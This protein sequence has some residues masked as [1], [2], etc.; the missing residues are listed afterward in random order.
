M[1]RDLKFTDAEI[2]AALRAGGGIFTHAALK[3]ECAPNTIKN[4]V[5]RSEYLQVVL[6]DINEENLDIAESV[7]M[8][9]IR[10]GNM[11]GVIFYLKTKGKKRGFSERFEI[12]GKDGGAIKHEYEIDFSG[13]TKAER[14]AIR[15]IFERRIAES[16]QGDSGAQPA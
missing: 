14:D 12:T 11:T 4:Y 9:A 2:E 6:E 10:D 15:P 5:L 1:G 13:L 8:R 3:L 7:L 16:D